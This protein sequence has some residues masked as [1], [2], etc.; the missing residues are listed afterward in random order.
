MLWV[1]LRGQCDIKARIYLKNYVNRINK[2]APVWIDFITALAEAL[3]S[4]EVAQC[5]LACRGVCFTGERGMPRPC[6]R[7]KSLRVCA[8]DCVCVCVRVSCLTMCAT[9]PVYMASSHCEQKAQMD[10]E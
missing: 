7:W 1:V 5:Q 3:C 8:S 2:S 6:R 4:E 10:T 9:V